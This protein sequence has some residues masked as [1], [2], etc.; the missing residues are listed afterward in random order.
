MALELKDS[1][2]KEEDG[3]YKLHSDTFF[4]KAPVDKDKLVES[5]EYLEEYQ[6]AAI[7]SAGDIVAAEKPEGTTLFVVDYPGEIRGYRETTINT[8]MGEDNKRR[9]WLSNT[10]ES[11]V[12]T[13][14]FNAYQKVVDNL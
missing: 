5:F 10:Y 8:V 7:R 12:V 9:S 1:W 11:Q 3:V 14:A 6:A 4:E 2:K 13:E